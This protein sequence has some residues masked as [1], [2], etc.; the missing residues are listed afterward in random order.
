MTRSGLAE[1]TPAR[2]RPVKRE[3][4][5]GIIAGFVHVARCPEAGREPP[6]TAKRLPLICSTLPTADRLEPYLR[7]ATDLGRVVDRLREIIGEPG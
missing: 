3:P 7:E 6:M 2:N 5:A 4:G 1:T